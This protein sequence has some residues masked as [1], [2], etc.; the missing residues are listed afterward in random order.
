MK[1]ASENVSEKNGKKRFT[2]NKI[3]HIPSRISLLGFRL[4]R[5]AAAEA[6][7]ENFGKVR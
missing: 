1:R 4:M 5:E 3:H 6:V 7:P 2:K